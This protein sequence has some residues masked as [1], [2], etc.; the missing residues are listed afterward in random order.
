[1][2]KNYT[3][4]LAAEERDVIR[5]D[6]LRERLQNVSRPNPKMPGNGGSL[7]KRN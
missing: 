3:E 2:Q 6:M 5:A 1:L 4:K 7:D